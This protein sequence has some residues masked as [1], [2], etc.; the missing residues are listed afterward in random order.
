MSVDK[1]LNLDR[2]YVYVKADDSQV[3][4]SY[5]SNEQD[6]RNYYQAQDVSPPVILYHLDAVVEQKAVFQDQVQSVVEAIISYNQSNDCQI[7]FS[8]KL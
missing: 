5:F 1:L 6:A 3:S 2:W 7:Q 8:L 4:Q